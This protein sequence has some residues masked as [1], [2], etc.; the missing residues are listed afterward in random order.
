MCIL[1][2]DRFLSLLAGTLDPVKKNWAHKS[3]PLQINQV[4]YRC[5]GTTISNQ[6]IFCQHLF[7]VE[8]SGIQKQTERAR[9][10]SSLPRNFKGVLVV[11]RSENWRNENEIQYLESRL[12]WYL[13]EL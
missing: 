5:M 1:Q 10:I 13:R 12:I 6:K 4:R 11:G 9:G 2:V 7:K 3:N 8:I